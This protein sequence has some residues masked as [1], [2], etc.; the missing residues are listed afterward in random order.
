M[1]SANSVWALEGSGAQTGDGIVIQNDA[2]Y[3]YVEGVF[4]YPLDATPPHG[5]RKRRCRA[6][7]LVEASACRRLVVE[8]A[9]WYSWSITDCLS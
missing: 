1:E 6:W 5:A 8:N 9:G 2:G 7:H 3:R 4:G